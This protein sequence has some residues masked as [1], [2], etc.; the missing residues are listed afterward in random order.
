MPDPLPAHPHTTPS[1]IIPH[2][3]TPA[4][5]DGH[6]SIHPLPT[7]LVITWELAIP[8]H[9]SIRRAVEPGTA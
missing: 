7:V 8:T 9:L 4:Q 5:L 1:H 6:P 3:P 2:L